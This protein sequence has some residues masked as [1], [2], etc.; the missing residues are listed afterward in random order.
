MNK[1]RIQPMVK[2]VA[3]TILDKEAIEEAIDGCSHVIHLAAVLGVKNTE[4]N[5]LNC[6]NINIKGTNNILEISSR[7]GVEKFLF[8]SSSEVYGEALSIPINEDSITQGKTAYG[9]SKLAGEEL[10]KAYSQKFPNLKYSILRFFNVFG[11]DQVNQFVVSKFI[12]NA[13]DGK[14]I[15]INGTGEQLRSYCYV[16][17]AVRGMIMALKSNNANSE[18]INIGHQFNLISLNDLAKLVCQTVG[19]SEE[20]ITNDLEFSDRDESREI[21]E[22]CPDTSKAKGLIGFEAKIGMEESIK[23]IMEESSFNED[24]PT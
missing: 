15:I 9:V 18:T 1:G 10:V 12:K 7:A 4:S 11:P 3:G 20:I 19:A 13:L 5:L 22:R 17:D 21:F 24:W 23:N 8:A 2:S 6:L 14:P 16:D